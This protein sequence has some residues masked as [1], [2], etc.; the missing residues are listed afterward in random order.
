MNILLTIAYDGTNYHGWQIQNDAI[1]IQEK[2]EIALV[3]V[4]KQN[5][6]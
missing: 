4:H 3:K 1:S 5:I 2:I 6:K